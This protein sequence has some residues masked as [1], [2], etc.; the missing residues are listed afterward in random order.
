MSKE[1][2]FREVYK[3]SLI[4]DEYFKKLPADI[5]MAFIDNEYV[6]NVTQER[7]MMLRLLFDEHAEAIEWFL[8]EWRPGS[9]VGFDTV[10]TKIN[11]IDEYIDFMKNNEGFV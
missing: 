4:R 5:C 2:L 10:V 11:N 6:N 1:Q 9:E 3:N 7:D 8:Y